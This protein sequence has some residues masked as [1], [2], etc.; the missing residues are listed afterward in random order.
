LADDGREGK[1]IDGSNASVGRT[2]REPGSLEQAP[3]DGNA[4]GLLLRVDPVAL[5]PPP[6]ATSPS[7]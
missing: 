3:R 7:S 1:R 2:N 4:N 5:A 6:V